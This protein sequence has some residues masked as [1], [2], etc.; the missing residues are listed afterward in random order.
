M[1]IT[2]NIGK[3]PINNPKKEELIKLRIKEPNISIN[4]CP[5]KTLA[6]RR[7]PKEKALEE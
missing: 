6:E 7:K 3:N 1:A 2:P 4:K 5:D